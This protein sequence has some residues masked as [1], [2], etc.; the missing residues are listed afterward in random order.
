MEFVYQGKGY[1][2]MADFCRK[3]N[4]SYGKLCRIRRKYR[5][6]AN[7]IEIAL[8]VVKGEL[9][10]LGD[11]LSNNYLQDKYKAKLRYLNFKEKQTTMINLQVLEI[12]NKQK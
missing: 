2:S 5:K 3:H 11:E 1:T 6:A 12:L 7:N 9:S 8:A 10:L 4:I